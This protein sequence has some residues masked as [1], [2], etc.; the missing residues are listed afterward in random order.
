MGAELRKKRSGKKTK[1]AMTEKQL[2]EF[3]SGRRKRR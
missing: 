3:A 2:R 1:T